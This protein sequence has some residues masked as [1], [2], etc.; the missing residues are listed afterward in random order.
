VAEV[1]GEA[2][3]VSSIDVL[4][5]FENGVCNSTNPTATPSFMNVDWAAAFKLSATYNFTEKL[6]ASIT[7]YYI[8]QF[9]YPITG[10]P[11]Y[12]N[13]IVDS[14]GNP[15]VTDNGRADGIWG[16]TEVAY[17]LTDHWSL[18]LGVW[19]GAGS[20]GVLPKTTS[21]NQFRFPFLDTY[22]LNSNDWD[23]YFDVTA[24]F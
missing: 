16:V 3:D 24:S 23:L 2:P 9:Y 18:S 11:A 13:P 17:A 7:F 12:N 14:N 1:P 19:N 22:S 15:V 20:T 4:E 5:G 8:D 10:N 21:G 6:T